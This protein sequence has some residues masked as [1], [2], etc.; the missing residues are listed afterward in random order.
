MMS[1]KI[2]GIYKITHHESGKCYIGQSVDINRRWYIHRNYSNIKEKNRSAIASALQKY[3]IDA[4]DFKILEECSRE[5]SNDREIYWIAHFGSLSPNG[6]NM[7]TGGGQAFTFSEE[8][9]RK[10]S[11]GQ[12]GQKQSEETRRK[13][14]EA[15]KGHVVTE[16]TR[17]KISKANKGEN[18]GM[19]GKIVSEETRRKLSE[20]LKG[21]KLG[22]K[23]GPLSEEH[24]YKL[25]QANKGIQ[26]KHTCPYCNKVGGNILKRYHFE[27]CKHKPE[28][29]A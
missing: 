7:N 23:Y 17:H 24:R 9:R 19:Y 27:N 15:M 29:V 3:G 25:S 20:S 4:F 18:N 12:K 13:R 2:C 26:K 1:T 10:M 11:E 6:Y 5:M 22:K 16:E 21:K 8:T 28:E 14:S